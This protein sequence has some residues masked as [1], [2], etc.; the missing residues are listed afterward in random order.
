MSPQSIWYAEQVNLE[1]LFISNPSLE[2]EFEARKKVIKKGNYIYLP[3]EVSNKIY[4]ILNG[5]VKIGTFRDNEKEIVTAILQT[6]DVFSEM[7]ILGEKIRKDFAIST[8]DCTLVAFTKSE[9]NVLMKNHSALSILMMRIMNERVI[10]MEDRL[11]SLIFKDSRTRILEFLISRIEK[12]GQRIGYEWVLRNFITHQDIASLT[13]TSRQTVTMILNDLRN[14][15]IIQFDRKR[16][17]VRD[18]D[19]LK[20]SVNK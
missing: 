15:N 6:G 19:K 2:T 14:N 13:S 20:S 10:E 5:K 1:A 16:L 3:E 18:L 7:S 4:F 8:T 17:L 9:L 12:S 11:E